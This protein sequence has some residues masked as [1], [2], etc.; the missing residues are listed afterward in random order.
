MLGMSRGQALRRVILPQAART[1]VARCPNSF[2]SLVKD[3][4]LAAT[5]QVPELFRQAQPDHRPHLRNLRHVSGGRRP[6]LDPVQPAGPGPDP[7]GT[8]GGGPPMSAIDAKGLVKRLRRHDR[9]QRRRPDRRARRDRRGH[10]PQRLGQEHPAALPGG[11]EV[12]DGG[13]LTVAGV[14]AGT[15]PPF[16]RALK[17]R[18]GFV[19]Q[20]FN[21]VPAPHGPAERGR[22]PDRGA[23][24]KPAV[25]YDKA[26]ALLTKV[27][28]AHRRRR[29][30]RASCPAASSNAAPS[31]APWP[32]IRRSSCSTEP[33][34][35]LDP[36]AGR[37]GAD[38]DPRSGRREADD[39]HRDPSDGLRRDV[40]D[41]TLFMDDGVIIEQAPFRRRARFA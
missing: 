34:S 16:A 12:I 25:A 39:G 17:G 28:L 30:P 7:A 41:R 40:A 36:G 9:R 23:R 14:T 31:P 35:A 24:R 27:G 10:R 15:K 11:L 20:S 8:P 1:A 3:T 38:G 19:F 37:R 5:I 33:T 2:I 18:V 4:S 6:L 13:T 26:R 21:L 29:L 22:G 32:W